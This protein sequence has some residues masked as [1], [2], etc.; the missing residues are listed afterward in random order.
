[1]SDSLYQYIVTSIR[2]CS[3]WLSVKDA[4]DLQCCLSG[5]EGQTEQRM[6]PCLTLVAY[7]SH[8]TYARGQQWSIPRRDLSRAVSSLSAEDNAFRERIERQ[9]PCLHDAERIVTTAT[10]GL[11]NPRLSRDWLLGL[12][13]SR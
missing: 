13:G 1:M 8:G 9:K 4:N 2:E 10:H 12:S 6:L 3:T 5:T 7:R 11:I